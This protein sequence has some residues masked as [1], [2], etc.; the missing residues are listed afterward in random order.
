MDKDVQNI[1]SLYTQLK[2]ARSKYVPL[3]QSIAEFTGVPLNVNAFD[4]QGNSKEATQLDQYVDDPTS[5]ISVTNAADYMIGIIWG[6]TGDAFELKPTDD[7][8]QNTT[9][10]QELL[11]YYKF[12]TRKVLDELNHPE[13]GMQAALKPYGVDQYAIGTSG[14]GIFK[15]P[16]YIAGKS[17]N[18]L[19]CRAYGVDNMVIDEGK[20]GMVEYI[21]VN[22]SWGVNRIVNEFCIENGVVSD[23]LLKKLPSV[24]QKA[25][26]N[27]NVNEQFR[28][29]HGIY[30]REDYNPRLKGQKG[31][32]YV[33]V[34]FMEGD[35]DNR[36]FASEDYKTIPIAVCR[37][38][39]MRGEVYGRCG[40]TMLISSIK[41]INFA[42]GQ[43]MEILEKMNEPSLLLANNALVGDSV[44]DSSSGS[45]NI[46]NES[47]LG[48]SKSPISPLYEVGN[49]QPIIQW[50]EPYLNSK[51]TSAFKL[52]MLL[53]FNS[54]TTMTASESTKRYIIRAQSLAGLLNQQF[55]ELVY[56]VA[57][58]S[59]SILQD[60]GLLGVE[61][62]TAMAKLY[63]SKKQNERIIPDAVLQAIK[64]GKAWFKVIPNQRVRSMMATESIE[65]MFQ[66]FNSLTLLGQ[67]NP[68][69]LMAV[70]IYG[71][72][73]DVANSLNI[74]PKRIIGE[75]QYK[76]LV[77]AQMQAQQSQLA[78]SGLSTGAAAAKDVAESKKALKDANG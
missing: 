27:N 51:I 53:D 49:P 67:L 19:I 60:L 75:Q 20:N 29:I 74:D 1:Q 7:V 17:E 24:I 41:T 21:F 40:G 35:K 47:L 31:A 9:N 34:W 72:L 59:T 18:C 10:D 8:L 58:R 54:A 16:A 66:F 13:S 64:S 11:D 32:R 38:I 23:K 14:I 52:D 39:K 48:N 2:T 55:T 30:P 45:I 73:K 61:P 15:N 3:W 44:L 56:N 5:A 25:Y 78:L 71:L 70:D 28:I 36:V 57:K 77:A 50:L 4:E 42:I 6:L 12:V 62:G 26:E 65:Q 37:Q 33:G 69:A 68:T 76:Q 22:Y 43:V 63:L 46:F